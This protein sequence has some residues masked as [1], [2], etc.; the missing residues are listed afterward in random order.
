[1][2]V[3]I[4]ESICLLFVL[5]VVNGP[6]LK[7]QVGVHLGLIMEDLWDAAVGKNHITTITFSLFLMNSDKS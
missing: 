3:E 5:H 6:I 1:M 7:I 2:I 4:F